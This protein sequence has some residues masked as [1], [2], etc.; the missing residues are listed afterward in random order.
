MN[1]SSTYPDAFVHLIHIPGAGTW[2]GAT[3]EV[4]FRSGNGKAFTTALAGTRKYQD[5]VDEPW[6]DKEREE[7]HMVEVHIKDVFRQCGITKYSTVG[8]LSV[9]AGSVQH[10]S[11]KL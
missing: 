4:L 7:Q 10:L 2:M 9:T 6:G 5:G 11:T 8:P 1:L 3:P